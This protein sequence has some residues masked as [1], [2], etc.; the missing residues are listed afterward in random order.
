MEPDHPFYSNISKDRRYADLTEDQLPS[1]E[2]L[3]D[4]IGQECF[5]VCVLESLPAL[6][7]GSE[8]PLGPVQVYL[9][10]ISESCSS[11]LTLPH[12]SSVHLSIT[13]LN[14]FSISV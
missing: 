4:T 6:F 12:G 11:C 14:P 8:M 1:C 3:K 7:H 10:L 5:L 13:V 9:S 2:S